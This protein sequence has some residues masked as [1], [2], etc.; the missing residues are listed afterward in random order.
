MRKLLRKIKRFLDSFLGDKSDNFYW[1]FYYYFKNGDLMAEKNQ[2]RRNFLF[3]AISESFPF[4][5]VL[6]I[7]SGYGH[8]LHLLAKELPEVTFY[9]IDIS[10]RAI[11]KGK[12]LFEVAKIS[13]VYLEKLDANKLQKYK[14]KSID[15]IFTYATIMYIGF[16]KID[17]LIKEIL[18]ITRKSII[19]CE[20]YTDQ[21]PFYND[22]WVYNYKKLFNKYIPEEK[23][24]IL[25]L[26]N[27]K[28]NSDWGK[29]GRIIRIKL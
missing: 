9:G 27:E 26:P 22:N 11:N 6:E 20:Q 5:A 7:G 19:L 10:G 8:N 29:F 1:K 15:I 28:K 16:D 24:E 2:K 3:Q 25:G 17:C 12:K 18:R 21:E 13:N 4:E 14:D 23:I